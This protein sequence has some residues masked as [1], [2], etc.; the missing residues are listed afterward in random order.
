MII[1]SWKD[2]LKER[3]RLPDYTLTK[4]QMVDFHKRF[5]REILPKLSGEK[6]EDAGMWLYWLSKAI[7]NKDTGLGRLFVSNEY[8]IAQLQDIMDTVISERDS[9]RG[10]E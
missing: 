3:E 1:M 5:T 7:K 8:I 2:I 9:F 6:E 4:E 10:M